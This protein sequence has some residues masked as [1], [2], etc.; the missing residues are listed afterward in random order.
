MGER[1]KVLCVDDDPGAAAAAAL[2][3]RRAGCEVRV[4]H[5]GPVALAAAAELFRPD[6]CVLDLAMPGMP[7]DEL[8]RRLLGRTNGRPVRL[9]ALTGLWDDE[10]RRRTR[11]AGFAEHLVKPV[12]PG[13]LVGAVTGAA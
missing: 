5:G 6:V 7:G 8:A 12:E 13:R 11:D 10:A 4:C 2:V 1:L 9:V 3:L